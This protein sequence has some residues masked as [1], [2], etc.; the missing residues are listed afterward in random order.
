M[1]V[2]VS[3]LLLWFVAGM[4]N[5][6][7]LERRDLICPLGGTGVLLISVKK[8]E[9]GG[10]R[11]PQNIDHVQLKCLVCSVHEQ[12]KVSLIFIIKDKLYLSLLH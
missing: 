6:I 7:Y 5:T 8:M 1:N 12:I 2:F 4:L 9:G 3:V 11:G 10:D